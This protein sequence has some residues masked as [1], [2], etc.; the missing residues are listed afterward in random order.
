MKKILVL[1]L[2]TCC[3]FLTHAQVKIGDN[4]TNIGVSSLLELES[5]NKA[6]V[7]TRVANTAAI[8]N[9]VN[10]MII[11]DISSN[12]LKSYENG[13]WTNCL[14]NGSNIESSTNGTAIVSAYSCSTASMGV[15]NVGV[16]V[17]MVTQRITATV[18][19][20][21]TYN[22]AAIS[23]GVAFS[24]SGT[25][26]TT[27][28]HDID[29]T[30]IGT[31]VLSGMH[32]FALNTAPGCNFTRNVID[33]SSGGTAHI[34][35]LGCPAS[36]PV[37]ILYSGIAVSGVSQTIPV[38]VTIPGTF[39]ISTTTANGVTFS[40]TGTLAAG[41][42]TITLT[43][44]GTPTT[45]VSSSTFTLD[46]TP[47]C[48]FTR[49]T[50]NRSS[51]GLAMISNITNCSN[52]TVGTLTAGVAIPA[53][54]V[55]QA[56][57]VTV[58]SISA[59]NTYNIST[60]A[61]NG[62]TWSGSGTFSGTGSY[63]INL[64]ASGTPIAAGAFTYPIDIV[65]TQT[66][67]TCT[68]FTRSTTE[69]FVSTEC[70]TSYNTFPQT[71][72]VG[73]SNVTVNYVSGS[74][75]STNT[76]NYSAYCGLAGTNATRYQGSVGATATY[77]FTIPLKNVQAYLYNGNS[78]TGGGLAVN[79]TLAGV[80][81][82]VQLVK[83][84]GC[85]TN[86]TTSQSGNTGNI[87]NTFAGTTAISFNISAPS[88]YDRI[89]ISY[90]GSGSPSM[91][92]NLRF[93]NA[94]AVPNATSGG[95]AV[96]ASYNCAGTST[97]TMTVGTAVSGVSQTVTANV[98]TVGAYN[99]T[100]APV[101][102]ITWSASGT[103]SGTGNQTI[104][105][106]A[107]GTPTTL[108]ANSFTLN[109]TPNCSFSRNVMSEFTGTVCTTQITYASYPANVTI[110]GNFV[111]VIKT[112][113]PSTA[114]YGT[115]CGVGLPG[116][117]QAPATSV[118][119]Q[120]TYDFTAPLK[121]VQVLA[122]DFDTNDAHTVTAFMD[123]TPVP[124]QLSKFGGT[125]QNDFVST[126][127]GN[128]ASIARPTGSLSNIVYNISS[129]TPYNKITFTGVSGTTSHA[130]MFC[131][132][133]AFPNATSGG[134]AVV[135]AYTCST[136]SAGNLYVNTAPSSVTQTITA[137]VTTVGTYSITTN[138]VDGV[139]FNAAGTFT[140]VGP[141]DIV[142]RATGTPTAIGT[143]TFTLAATPNCTFNRDVVLSPTT[144]G[145]AVVSAYSCNTNSAGTMTE[146][147][148]ITA[149]SVT[150]T[151]T[152]TVTTVGT[153]D[154]STTTANGVT[155]AAT[156]TF[157]GIGAQ[158]IVLNATGT[159]TAGGA[160]IPF[161][162]NTTPNCNFTRPIISLTSGGT[163]IVSSYNCGSL[164]TMYGSLTVGQSAS[165]VR[166][167][168]T[169]TVPSGG[170][171]TYSISIPTL[172]GITW[173][174]SGSLSVGS[175]GI[176]L[177][178]SGTPTQAGMIDYALP[179]SVTCTF[180]HL[181]G[182]AYTTNS[183]SVYT[184]SNSLYLGSPS[185]Y[186]SYTTSGNPYT[187]NE[188]GNPEC[189]SGSGGFIRL[190]NS[191]YVTYDF[192]IPLKNVQVI[193]FNNDY[194]EGNEGYLVTAY[195]A[196][197]AV[198]VQAVK[199]SGCTGNFS[200]YQSSDGT[201]AYVVNDYNEGGGKSLVFNISAS[202]TYDRLTI[203]RTGSGGSASNG[204]GLYFC[205]ATAVGNP[206]SGGT[207]VISSFNCAGT[208]TG[209]LYVNT[210]ASG[211]TQNITADVTTGGYYNIRTTS[212]DGITW[213]GSGTVSSGTN[214]TITLS[215]S[216]TPTSIGQKSFTLDRTPNC[217]FSRDV[218][219]SNTSGGTAVISSYNC[220]GY[221]AGTTG[222][223]TEGTDTGSVGNTVTQGVRITAT[224]AGTYNITTNTVNGVTFSGTGNL[225]VGTNDII[226][227]ASGTP[228]TGSGSSGDNFTVN[229]G[230]SPSCSFNRLTT[231][232]TSNGTAVI[233]SYN[234]TSG[235]SNGTLYVNTPPS[236]VSKVVVATVTKAG[237]YSISVSVDGV[238]YANSGTVSTGTQ[239]ITL[240][241][242]GTPTSLGNK[243]FTLNTTPNCMFSKTVVNSLT[244]G[245]T[246]V[247]SGYNCTGTVTGTITVG[248]AIP[249]N[250][251]KQRIT[252]TA[253]T[254]G[255]YSIATNTINGITWTGSGSLVL[256]AN[257]I[258]LVASGTPTAVG[259]SSFTVNSGNSPTC[260]FT[261]PVISPSTG[262]TAVVSA[263]NCAITSTSI[264]SNS[265][266]TLIRGEA[267]PAST[268]TYSVVATVTTAGTYDITIPAVNG[269]TWTSTGSFGGTG[270]NTLTFTAS[271]TPLASG[272]TTFQLPTTP[273]CSFTRSIGE[274][275]TASVC[276]AML[277]NT[278]PQ[279]VTTNDGSSVTVSRTTTGG[280]F[281]STST[282]CSL[283]A[284]AVVQPLTGSQNATY[285]FSA[286]VKNVQ[287]YGYVNN[288]NSGFQVTATLN[289]VAVPIQLVKMGGNCQANFS[290]FQSVASAGS[291]HT[292]SSSEAIVYNISAAGLYDKLVVTYLGTGGTTY[293][294]LMLCNASTTP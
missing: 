163:A 108:G 162:L 60:T 154:I 258:E 161:V 211:V 197:V 229:N 270:S 283:A 88:G 259:T 5:T 1:L 274:P 158:Q 58:S 262:G 54:S 190:Q 21:G 290:T 294:N 51:G 136:A 150:Q 16:P 275:F 109:T 97:G 91:F 143:K 122:I 239:N 186:V 36:T 103:F 277:T 245:G 253:T 208:S 255:T 46:T 182:E 185:T 14:S 191:Q 216:G 28:T 193:G 170:G 105:L 120:I 87:I 232:L 250:T 226:L 234:C 25:F 237:S 49:Q 220:S 38:T 160:A 124:V 246:A 39:V 172:N 257:D 73:S 152:A 241:A 128:S 62:V 67:P 248:V 92:Y 147:T 222:T 90:L 23:N 17:N 129:T 228:I 24:A 200:T 177:Y 111:S 266:G 265:N 291:N 80:A 141:Q 33:L 251:V 148:A 203:Q 83:M 3:G 94:T 289:G 52:A 138:E 180:S 189:N 13:A 2:I 110:G 212:A 115:Y 285:T 288:G 153:Y 184:Q 293:H 65:P 286:P 114:A 219:N 69:A 188:N 171:G 178:A 217:S 107:S 34:S 31:P 166:H 272:S 119:Q 213:S 48:N 27:G 41:E 47:N 66:T 261:R 206:T 32:S 252:V 224:T 231:S 157:A 164:T 112:G 63:T 256:G 53:N 276:G 167:Y 22:I 169:A 236:G 35:V 210:P 78:S 254:A 86:F 223:M 192:N 57:T 50:V 85:D 84:T 282:Y 125:C 205:N 126:Q 247:I 181:T 12:C 102:G 11:Y 29:L 268:V 221:P 59:G 159:P 104:T 146:G 137:N 135:S 196:G 4:P 144:N 6:L 225:V 121:N 151:I 101:N 233:S 240:N 134:T 82:P 278:Y 10:G 194:G 55:Y 131:N 165:G 7:V 183:C 70:L 100:T 280:G 249:A 201:T 168:I 140:A 76:G 8:T 75:D 284:A 40:G 74:N 202:S 264:G 187:W 45:A 15:M 271:G 9:P 118:G 64:Y 43:A 77:T 292:P 260:S 243:D 279:A 106:N 81:V 145:T 127:S 199:V 20:V 149:N 89:T 72:T 19:Q 218:V 207:A 132:A 123:A 155:F 71:V 281:N 179:T 95:S 230:N 244:S 269:I 68:S 79:A 263:Y 238:T 227:T 173:S 98:T 44:S 156:G 99:I 116:N 215:A 26:S 204:F 273:N 195:L 142:L 133:T 113:S 287:L 30:A 214:R 176:W 139:S 18:T 61:V 242:T 209:T 175:N 37:G 96:V 198:K 235:A 42:Q 117:P 130:L 267:I 56:I 93:C 174:A